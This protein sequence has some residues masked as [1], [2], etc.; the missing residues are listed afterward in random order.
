MIFRKLP[1]VDSFN[2]F[3]ATSCPIYSCFHTSPK[4]PRY[5]GTPIMLLGNSTRSDLGSRMWPAHV[6]Y[7]D[8]R[9]F[10]RMSGARLRSSKACKDSEGQTAMPISPFPGDGRMTVYLVEDIDEGLGVALLKTAGQINCLPARED[11]LNKRG[12]FTLG[13]GTTDQT[14]QGSF[15]RRRVLCWCLGTGPF[16]LSVISG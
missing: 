3:T 5:N 11:C 12:S 7:N 15:T 8:F 2:T 1:L 16:G 4:P 13:V 6:L 9:H 10:F 14:P